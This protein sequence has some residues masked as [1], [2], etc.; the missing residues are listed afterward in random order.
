MGG[1]DNGP[2]HGGASTS[3]AALGYIWHMI[4]PSVV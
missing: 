3:A 1:Q 4:D 2:A